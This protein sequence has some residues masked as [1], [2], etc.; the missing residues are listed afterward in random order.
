MFMLYIQNFK[1]LLVHLLLKKIKLTTVSRLT[2]LSY[3]SIV[4]ILIEICSRSVLHMF[5]FFIL[6]YF[7]SFQWNKSMQ[8]MFRI[9][10]ANTSSGQNS[11]SLITSTEIVLV[12]PVRTCSPIVQNV[13]KKASEVFVLNFHCFNYFPMF[14]VSQHLDYC[15]NSVRK[16]FFMK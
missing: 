9:K 10:S 2:I 1:H 13:M 6:S 3:Q 14:C 15:I 4:G 16:Y 12:L 5:H 11:S 7:I 8:R